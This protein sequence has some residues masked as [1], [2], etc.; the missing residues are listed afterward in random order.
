[1]ESH[2]VWSRYI[3]LLVDQEPMHECF[4]D[5]LYAGIGAFSDHDEFDFHWHLTHEDLVQ[6]GFDMKAIDEDACE[7]KGTSD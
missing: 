6:A 3:G 5:A 7:P 4:S 1:M 2:P